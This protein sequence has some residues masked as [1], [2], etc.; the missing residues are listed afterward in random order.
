MVKQYMVKPDMSV[1]E[2]VNYIDIETKK[3]ICI[4]DNDEKL[5][6]IFTSGDMRRYAL[7][8]GDMS[9]KISEVMNCKPIVFSSIEEAD[10]AKKH[11]SLVAYPVIDKDRVLK[12]II[13]PDTKSNKFVISKELEKVPLIIMAGG[14][15]T[16][17]YP[18]T[19]V[20]PKALIPI[21]DYTISERI[22]N[23]FVKYGCKEVHFILNYKA[24]MIKAYFNE[25]EKDYSV[26][27]VEEKLFLGTGGGLKLL[28]DKISNTFIVSN[29]DILVNADLECALKIHRENNNKITFICAMKDVI[30]PYGVIDANEDGK[31]ER[32]VEK[33]EYSFLTNTGVYIVEP[34]IMEMIEENEFIHFP[35]IARKC[36][37][38]GHNV[39]V[40]P[41]SSKAWLDMGQFGEMEQ[42]IKE[43]E[44][45]N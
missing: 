22:I 13:F 2:A 37:E 19:K 33:P 45:Q 34:G 20:L 11:C 27:Y 10:N 16:R 42:M 41:V 31:I 32:I 15:G 25:L 5:L 7:K 9:R 21:G 23:N 8:S 29:C 6:G 17:L 28:Q 39:G 36:I 3:I 12:Q 38:K 43:V 24:G 14:R 18:Y 4:V 30:I 26:D 40:F 44:I 1:R 35:D